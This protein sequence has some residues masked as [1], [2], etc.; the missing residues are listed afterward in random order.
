MLGS[1]VSH[2]GT[3][4]ERMIRISPRQLIT[5]A[6]LGAIALLVVVLNQKNVISPGGCALTVFFAAVLALLSTPSD[7]P[8]PE[9]LEGLRSSIKRLLDG[10]K[11]EAVTLLT[12]VAITK[13]NLDKAE[14]IGELK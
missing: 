8:S 6:I 4:A 10:K 12:P 11:P 3:P 5:I 13:E 9:Q 7:G 14:R 2:L 1:S